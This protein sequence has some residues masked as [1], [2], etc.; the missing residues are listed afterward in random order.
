[1]LDSINV[2]PYAF[3]AVL[4]LLGGG[5]ERVIRAKYLEEAAVAAGA[6]VGGDNAVERTVAL[7]PAREAYPDNHR[8]RAEDHGGERD[9]EDG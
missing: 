9:E 3:D 6:R 4:L 8:A 1:M 5:G 7:A 2:E